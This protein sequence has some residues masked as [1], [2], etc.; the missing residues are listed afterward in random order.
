[1]TYKRYIITLYHDWIEEDGYFL[2]WDFKKAFDTNTISYLIILVNT[3]LLTHS[4]LL[5]NAI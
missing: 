1:M 3:G 2:F 5:L 4:Y